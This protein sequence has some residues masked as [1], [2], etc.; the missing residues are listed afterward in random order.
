MLKWF[1]L[2]HIIAT[3]AW[4]Q[5]P[6]RP[7]MKSYKKDWTLSS[8]HT[9]ANRKPITEGLNTGNRGFSVA[10]N[11][12]V[13]EIRPEVLLTY[14]SWFTVKMKP[15][16]QY[17]IS[18]IQKDFPTET[19]TD[20][21]TKFDLKEFFAEFLQLED[22]RFQ[23]GL[24]TYQWGPAEL[25]SPSNSLFHFYR[26][27]KS[28]SFIEKGY[29]LA[30]AI[31]NFSDSTN[32]QLLLELKSNGEPDWIRDANATKR[33]LFKFEHTF[34]NSFNYLGFTFGET[35]RDRTFW[36][37]YGNY[38]PEEGYSMYLDARVTNGDIGYHPVA[39]T[40]GIVDLELSQK[41]NPSVFAIA[42]FRFEGS[43]DIRLETLFFQEGF[44]NQEYGLWLSSLSPLQ[45]RF[46][47]NLAASTQMG[48][49]MLTRQYHYLSIR[50]PDLGSKNDISAALRSL[51][52]VEG[53][54]QLHT[55]SVDKPWGQS[56]NVYFEYAANQGEKNSEFMLSEKEKVS[57]G[58]KITYF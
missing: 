10:E 49:E 19:K 50:V 16:L 23:I 20:N 45:P 56:A 29:I 24:L 13:N 57:L 30:N 36:G 12:L 1:L 25:Y 31:Y 7:P 9:Y 35:Y 22:L 14:K 18:Q 46:A 37:L 33:Y 42:G 26:D 11:E 54:S 41:V 34:A 21:T 51:F 43:V 40:G 17:S 2:L 3:T 5:Q 47:Q 6:K 28:F 52:S 15:S 38:V 39:K 53:K 8:W 58:I 32:L 44:D 55:F 48:L 27:S 4:A